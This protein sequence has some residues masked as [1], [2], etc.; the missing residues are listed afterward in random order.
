MERSILY[1]TSDVSVAGEPHASNQ[2]VFPVKHLSVLQGRHQNV[3]LMSSHLE[4]SHAV[5]VLSGACPPL[6]GSIAQGCFNMLFSD[7]TPEPVL[8]NLANLAISGYVGFELRAYLDETSSHHDNH[9]NVL[10][11]T[12]NF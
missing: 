9:H 5:L 2:L 1:P 10:T 11:T 4:R 7:W 3:W 12:A 6:E 8:H